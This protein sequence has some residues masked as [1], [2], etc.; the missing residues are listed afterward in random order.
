VVAA[1]SSA[2]RPVT[3]RMPLARTDRRTGW[4]RF[5]FAMMKADAGNGK[6]RY[7]KMERGCSMLIVGC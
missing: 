2:N 3:K 4:N 5:I 1:K 6:R 7:E